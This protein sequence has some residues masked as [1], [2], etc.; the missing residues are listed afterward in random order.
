[1]AAVKK[2]TSIE[3]FQ[4]FVGDSSSLHVLKIGANWCGPCRVLEGTLLGLT[5]EEVE[6]VSLA[7]VN[8]DDEWFEDKAVELK[9]RGIPVLIAF[10]GGEEVDRLTGNVQKDNIISW[11]GRIK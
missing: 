1:M 4:E 9:V 11:F 8:A 7:E 3:E 5:Q 2:I 6:G 10:K